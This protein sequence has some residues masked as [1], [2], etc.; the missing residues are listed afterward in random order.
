MKKEF[1]IQIIK[2]I[3]KIYLYFSHFLDHQEST[4]MNQATLSASGPLTP[5]AA[6]STTSS[7]AVV[8]V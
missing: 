3:L 4:E 8:Q 2:F 5:G 1:Q 7:T 6:T